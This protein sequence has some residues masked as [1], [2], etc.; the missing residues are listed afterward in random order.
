MP[1]ITLPVSV[2]DLVEIVSKVAIISADG[3]QIN[4]EIGLI[5]HLSGALH[6]ILVRSPLLSG[7]CVSLWVDVT[8]A[9][10]PSYFCEHRAR[11][12]FTAKRGPGLRRLDF[13]LAKSLYRPRGSTMSIKRKLTVR[14]PQPASVI[15]A[16]GPPTPIAFFDLCVVHSF[17]RA[18]LLQAICVCPLPLARSDRVRQPYYSVRPAQGTNGSA[19]GNSV[20]N[21]T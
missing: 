2:I 6:Y 12:H 10:L 7:T 20:Q 5:V 9:V 4:N 16:S 17:A 21:Y 15:E 11:P 14:A 13:P 19:P 18:H 3:R 8:V 1:E